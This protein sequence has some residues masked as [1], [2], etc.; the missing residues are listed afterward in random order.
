MAS[1]A[2]DVAAEAAAAS[3]A[4][5]PVPTGHLVWAQC[6]RAGDTF[7]PEHGFA[8]AQ[9]LPPAAVRQAP[10]VQLYSIGEERKPFAVYFVAM[11]PFPLPVPNP[12]TYRIH[13]WSADF[14]PFAREYGYPDIDCYAG[15]SKQN[16]LWECVCI[17]APEG[18]S[19]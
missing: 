3:F 6:S 12:G 2:E 18:C 7:V 17:A 11:E 10:P 19:I 1:S 16:L 14:P 4:G 8:P 13:G 5:V 9:A 15:R